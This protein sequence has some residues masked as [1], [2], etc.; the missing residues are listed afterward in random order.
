MRIDA[1]ASRV[2]FGTATRASLGYAAAAVAAYAAALHDLWW[3]VGVCS[4]AGGL[5][6][7]LSG[8]HWIRSYRRDPAAQATGE[9]ALWLVAVVALAVTGL[10]LLVAAH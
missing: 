10:V 3:L 7:A 5:A 6:Y 4:L 2:V 8:R 9:S 1:F